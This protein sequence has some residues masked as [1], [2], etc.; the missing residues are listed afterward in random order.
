MKGFLD[1][2]KEE[3]QNFFNEA[4]FKDHYRSRV[5]DRINGRDSG[6]GI[7]SISTKHDLKLN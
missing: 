7:V 6:E 1:I 2:I 5:A 3:I 4:N